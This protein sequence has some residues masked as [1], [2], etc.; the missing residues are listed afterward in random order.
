MRDVIGEAVIM[1]MMMMMMMMMVMMMMMMMMMTFS[2]TP[3]HPHQATC[4]P[5]MCVVPQVWGLGFR[6]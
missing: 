1:M 5:T 3:L 6:V 2:Q 4:L